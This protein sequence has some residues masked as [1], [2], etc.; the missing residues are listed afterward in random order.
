MIIVNAHQRG[1]YLLLI[2]TIKKH[3]GLNHHLL[4][5]N[6]RQV[7]KLLTLRIIIDQTGI[8]KKFYPINY[9]N[10]LI[11]VIGI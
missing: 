4:I 3:N 5:L 9:I 6:C 11:S 7:N 2:I 10:I 1:Q 8:E